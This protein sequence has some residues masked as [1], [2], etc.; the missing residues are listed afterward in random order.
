MYAPF[1]EVEIDFLLST[2][3]HLDH[4]E[5]PL[6]KF[7]AAHSNCRFIGPQS[8]VE[9]MRENGVAN[10]RIT[11]VKPGD[12]TTLGS[13]ELRSVTLHDPYEADA[14][15]MVVCY[16]DLSVL[17]GGDS[18]Y[19]QDFTR[20]AEELSI[21][22]ALLS[23]GLKLYMTPEEIFAAAADLQCRALVPIHWDIW[24]ALHIPIEDI[25]QSYNQRSTQDFELI[26]MTAGTTLVLGKKDDGLF[27]EIQR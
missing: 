24:K 20:L 2:H 8:S 17:H 11:L 25:E 16:Q 6:I 3:A 1:R 10:H 14:L 18:H 15:G 7:L 5:P 19:S 27:H 4:C 22:L 12:T 9:K 21:D 23:S 13:L 26:S